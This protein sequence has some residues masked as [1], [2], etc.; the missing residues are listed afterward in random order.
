MKRILWLGFAMMIALSFGAPTFTL[1][2]PPSPMPT[3][4]PLPVPDTACTQVPELC[5]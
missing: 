3:P 4:S 1:A 5:L 2:G